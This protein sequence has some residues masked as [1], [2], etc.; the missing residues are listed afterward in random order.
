MVP[1]PPAA[2]AHSTQLY[3]I[4]WKNGV[5]ARRNIRAT[6][7]DAALPIIL[8][9]V[10]IALS[11]AL[12]VVTVPPQADS[13][14]L[15]LP[16]LVAVAAGLQV[17][18]APCAGG[19][20]VNSFATAVAASL[21]ANN[22]GL[23]VSCRD[24]EDDDTC[25]DSVVRLYGTNYSTLL[26]AV[27]FD[28]PLVVTGAGA[29][30]TPAAYRLRLDSSFLPN[31][32]F[33]NSTPASAAD[34]SA[35]APS[36]AP[37]AYI[38][39]IL[40][41]L[42][43]VDAAIADVATAAAAVA[44][45]AP[46]SVNTKQFPVAGYVIN[47]GSLTL[48]ATVPIYFVII[49]SVMV[50]I[51]LTSILEEKEKGITLALLIAGLPRVIHVA[52]WALSFAAQQAVAVTVI[53]LIAVFGGIFPTTPFTLVWLFFLLMLATCVAFT[54]AA[55]TLFS[56]ARTGGAIGMLLYI[57]LSLPMYALTNASAATKTG[58]GILAPCAFSMG[59]SMLVQAEG[60]HRGVTWATVGDAGVSPVG[61]SMAALLGMLALDTVL[62][63]LLAVYLDAVI[64]TELG[65]ANH[66]LLCC[67]RKRKRGVDGGAITAAARRS[68]SS[69]SGGGG[70][71]S[72]ASSPLLPAS[73]SAAA[74]AAHLMVGSRS[75]SD[76]LEAVS[77]EVA[78]R[79][80][81][82]VRSLS[83]LFPGSSGEPP[84]L[85]L[86][87]LDVAFFAGQTTCLL[88]P[89]GSGK[90]TL[91]R[92]LVGLTAPTSGGIDV[93]GLD[94]ATNLDAVRAQI[95][96]CPQSDTALFDRLTVEEHLM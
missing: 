85:A 44:A 61:V 86:D 31:V 76:D 7:R 89:N 57:V 54:F 13:P 35:L 69:K 28:S 79:G 18:I 27:V 50:R 9:A 37:A 30:T 75:A 70:G 40:P 49:F 16:P 41:L 48:Q 46:F 20:P 55:S 47:V 62:Y 60:E 56:K 17:W 94:L 83:K 95:G 33:A 19:A 96:F 34:G 52:G 42:A 12:G 73:S 6:I 82:V 84:C 26:G 4:L 15:P 36:S 53:A 8:L 1:H 91:Q 23:K 29:I 78:A 2:P 65:V 67:R 45:P 92:I 43:G 59:I 93:F 87:G 51:G 32:L 81:V 90:S 21:A 11:T 14:S 24:C 80:G 5:L 68:A 63:A 58:V 72:A 3:A 22:A 64:P 10:M 25:L 39:F 66:P 38:P 71:G 88:G 77:P 74:A